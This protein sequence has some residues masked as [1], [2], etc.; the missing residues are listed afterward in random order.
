MAVEKGLKTIICWGF[1]RCF[2]V[3]YFY[4]YYYYYYHYYYC[5][6][7]NFSQKTNDKTNLKIQSLRLG[8][9][10]AT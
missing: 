2:F 3:Y 4:Q 6:L 5:F 10:T 1:L 9:F 8:L 7:F